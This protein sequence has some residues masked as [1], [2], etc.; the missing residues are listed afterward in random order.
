MKITTEKHDV[1]V[2][3]DM[4]S[5]TFA[6]KTSPQAFQ[7]LSSGLYTNKIK[8]VLRELGCNAVDAHT[9]AGVPEKPIEVKLPNA[10]DRQFYV[11]DYGTGLSDEQVMRLYTTYFDSTKQQSD[12]FIGGFGV[13]SKSPFAYTDS[14][15][16]ESRFEGMKRLYTAYVNEDGIPTITKMGEEPT[17][18]PNG[19]TIGFPV[20]PED[21]RNFYSE[22]Q[23]TYKWFPITPV[24]KGADLKIENTEQLRLGSLWLRARYGY[25]YDSNAYVRM[26][27]VAYPMGNLFNEISNAPDANKVSDEDKEYIYGA[28][29]MVNSRPWVIDLPIGSSLVA[30]SREAL[31]FD[32][33]SVVSLR[34]N[35]IKV[36]KEAVKILHDQIQAKSKNIR[37]YVKNVNQWTAEENLYRQ[38]AFLGLLSKHNP[39]YHTDGIR[40]RQE[41]YPALQLVNVGGLYDILDFYNKLKLKS[42]LNKNLDSD[43]VQRR[44]RRKIT[45][46]FNENEQ[47][48]DYESVESFIW[49]LNAEK[50]AVWPHEYK[51][52]DLAEA[53]DMSIAACNKSMEDGLR[54]NYLLAKRPGATDADFKSDLNK[55]E[56][57][58]ELKSSDLVRPI[59]PPPKKVVKTTNI[60]CV[61]VVNGTRHRQGDLSKLSRIRM[62]TS[63]ITRVV[64][65]D[66]TVAYAVFDKKAFPGTDHAPYEVYDEVKD[67]LA[68][69]SKFEG[70]PETKALVD[71]YMPED[72]VVLIEKSDLAVFKSMCPDAVPFDQVVK[73][74]K[75]DKEFKSV[76]LNKIKN[77][78]DNVY[79]GN[80]AGNLMN[81]YDT[82]V[83]A[84]SN[85]ALEQ[86]K[87]G[88]IIKEWKSKIQSSEQ[89]S[90]ARR[91]IEYLIQAGNQFFGWKDV[92]LPQT[93]NLDSEVKEIQEMYPLLSELNYW[94]S[95]GKKISEYILQMD[96]LKMYRENAYNQST[97]MSI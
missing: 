50:I 31:Q 2:S 30:A 37:E 63:D 69:I 8:A 16:V 15:T 28:S 97:T 29:A 61:P 1:E 46:S 53:I 62:L 76:V 52:T 79:A 67:R 45:K 23:D 82:A 26:G 34:E 77:L 33:R 85:H 25:G 11:K 56:T 70:V 93:L 87:I 57:F 73:K 19:L 80:T 48:A 75:S 20:K 18:E 88:Q 38:S 68:E 32:K 72:G 14:F 55:L 86:T 65:D 81:F 3:G 74:M 6:I 22:A 36:T 83:N 12:N 59:K 39:N 5:N 43:E 60:Y 24:I 40:I 42:K 96:E 7:L 21:V 92:Q 64:E 10:L 58:L 44:I 78:P 91:S 71:K 66:E 51:E 89:N 94:N 84:T 49:E 27:S 90:Q 47:E 41:D 95:N 17:D 9:A 35:V 4:A 54:L 13:G